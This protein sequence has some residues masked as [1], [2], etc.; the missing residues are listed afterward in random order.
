MEDPLHGEN[1]TQLPGFLAGDESS[2]IWGPGPDEGI[3]RHCTQPGSE[4]HCPAARPWSSTDS[5][6]NVSLAVN[7]RTPPGSACTAALAKPQW[8]TCLPPSDAGGLSAS[9]QRQLHS[10]AED[11]V[12]TWLAC[13][14]SLQVSRKP[15]VKLT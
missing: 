1:D 13:A 4:T 5:K 2:A 10:S 6:D 3:A 9:P 12:P 8:H 7:H 14:H 15:H 11:H